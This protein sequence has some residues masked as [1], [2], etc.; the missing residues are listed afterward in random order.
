MAPTTTLIFLAAC[1]GDLDNALPTALVERGEFRVVLDI[2]GELKALNSSTLNAPDVRGQI[3]ITEVIEEGTRVKEGDVLVRIDTSD[4]ETELDNALNQ[5]EIARTKI[6]QQEAQLTVRLA[7]LQTD[8][9]RAELG[10]ERA[11]LRL[12]ESET[13]PRVERESARL[14]A[15]ESDLS[16]TRSQAG[17]QAARLEGEGQLRLLQLEVKQA[18]AKVERIR[19]QIVNCT[20]TAPTDGLVIL[21]SIWKGG[22]RGPIT[23]G[24]TVYSGSSL[25][26]LPDLSVMEIESWVHEIDASRVAESL[27]VNVVID[28]F[29]DPTHAGTISR[30]A[31]LAVKRDRN[32]AIKHLKV[33]VSLEETT[34]D[35]KPGMTTRV[36]V[37]IETI[38]DVIAIPQ[39]AIFYTDSEPFLYQ[40]SL[41]GWRQQPVTLGTRNDTHVVITDGLDAGDVVALTDPE[42]FETGESGGASRLGGAANA[43][44]P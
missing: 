24:D 3:K 12:T 36:E 27:L 17:L 42:T 39:E 13:V 14:D 4:L 28:A 31:N 16:L 44:Q 26:E 37:L 9:R 15:E 5:L 20:I 18:E 33:M 40:R 32:S 6:L 2:P 10:L 35:M 25:V 1:G 7:D 30:V 11:G 38:P 8:I 41:G 19:E 34:E 23:E 29:P 21:P 22:S 43:A